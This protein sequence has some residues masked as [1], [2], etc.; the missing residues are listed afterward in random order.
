MGC[1]CRSSLALTSARGFEPTEVPDRYR[2]RLRADNRITGPAADWSAGKEIGEFRR[3]E[4]FSSYEI[5]GR[6][7]NAAPSYYEYTVQ[8]TRS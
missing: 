3:I 2:F 6:R 7:Y 1:F 5:T 8:F 4:R